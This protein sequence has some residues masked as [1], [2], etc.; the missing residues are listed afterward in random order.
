MFTELKAGHVPVNVGLHY[1]TKRITTIKGGR[2]WCFQSPGQKEEIRG[3]VDWLKEE[4]PCDKNS[5][6]APPPEGNR[7]T[8]MIRYEAERKHQ[9]GNL[10]EGA[11]EIKVLGKV[12]LVWDILDVIAFN[13]RWW[14]LTLQGKREKKRNEGLGQLIGQ[15]KIAKSG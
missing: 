1:Q 11:K 15:F 8:W 6:A 12:L 5:G 13:S 10:Y 14:K 7:D 9:G 4:S 3:K 2:M